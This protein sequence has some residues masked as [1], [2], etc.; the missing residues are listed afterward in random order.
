MNGDDFNS[1]ISLEG[2]SATREV[3]WRMLYS[4]AILVGCLQF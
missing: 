2:F 4:G 1:F 3:P